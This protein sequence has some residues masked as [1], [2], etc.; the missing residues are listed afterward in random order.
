[1]VRSCAKNRVG[2]D[3]ARRASEFKTKPAADASMA[4]LAASASTSGGIG[5]VTL[6]TGNIGERGNSIQAIKIRRMP[7][8]SAV[9]ILSKV[10]TS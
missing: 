3:H 5:T 4:A 8:R 9:K 1:V 6:D 10:A 7:K 2:T